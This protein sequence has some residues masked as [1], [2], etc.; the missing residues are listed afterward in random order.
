MLTEEQTNRFE[1]YRRS[2]LARP[3]VKKVGQSPFPNESARTAW[4]RLG[5]GPHPRMLLPS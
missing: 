1:S 2:S 3:K 5:G 4:A